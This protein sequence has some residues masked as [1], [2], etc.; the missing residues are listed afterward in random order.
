MVPLSLLFSL[1]VGSRANHG[2]DPCRLLPPPPC[3]GLF[4]LEPC[5][6]P[7]PAKTKPIMQIT[8]MCRV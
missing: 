8:A 5:L 1:R 7:A 6:Q 3:V 2:I 4:R